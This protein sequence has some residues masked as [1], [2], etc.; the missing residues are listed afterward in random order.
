[1]LVSCGEV[2]KLMGEM[3]PSPTPAQSQAE[4][5]VTICSLPK[6]YAQVS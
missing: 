5:T 3:L 6:A 2:D 4:L 1:V